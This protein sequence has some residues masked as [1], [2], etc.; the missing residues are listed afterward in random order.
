MATTAI[1]VDTTNNGEKSDFTATTTTLY[2]S[3]VAISTSQSIVLHEFQ[4]HDTTDEAIIFSVSG[5]L[6]NQLK[7]LALSPGPNMLHGKLYFRP[8]RT[9]AGIKVGRNLFE[10][11][12]NNVEYPI[13]MK[14]K[15][16]DA[17]LLA[18]HLG[19]AQSVVLIPQLGKPI[20]ANPRY[21]LSLFT[22]ISTGRSKA[23]TNIAVPISA[24][25]KVRHLHANLLL[26]PGNTLLGTIDETYKED[27]MLIF[28]ANAVTPTPVF[29]LLVKLS[30]SAIK[31]IAQSSSGSF[32]SNVEFTIDGYL[33]NY[34][35]VFTYRQNQITVY[36]SNSL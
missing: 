3:S 10:S 21:A 36:A 1:T 28:C 15:G 8:E 18:R 5:T 29:S 17:E 7:A 6:N 32:E 19:E 26:Y 27:K 31:A 33:G 25:I 12:I 30:I 2:S 23:Q 13:T 35:I 34:P 20:I 14:G 24:D 11:F 4:V 9:A 16:P 22:V